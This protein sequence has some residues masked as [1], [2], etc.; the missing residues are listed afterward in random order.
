MRLDS[1]CILCLLKR[2]SESSAKYGDEEQVTA[3][4]RDLMGLICN[5][6]V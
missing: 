3:F 5:G 4:T 1:Q 2:H 6:P